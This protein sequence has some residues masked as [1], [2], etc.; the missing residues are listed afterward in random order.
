MA[1]TNATGISAFGF[2]NDAAAMAAL[3]KCGNTGGTDPLGSFDGDDE[4]S[5]GTGPLGVWAINS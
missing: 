2:A 5:P 1:S 4:G 3:T